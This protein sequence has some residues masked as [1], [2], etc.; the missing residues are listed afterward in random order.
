[1]RAV[2][3]TA[4]LCNPLRDKRERERERNHHVRVAERC[5]A[6]HLHVQ[7]SWK[8]KSATETN[9]PINLAA[10][11][12]LGAMED[13]RECVYTRALPASLG[14]NNGIT[15]HGDYHLVRPAAFGRPTGRV[16]R[17]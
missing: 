16:M 3:V 2:L 12:R 14:V 9:S 6:L 5:R 8:H 1:M 4:H 13:V 15:N 7:G 17:L 10:K 11:S